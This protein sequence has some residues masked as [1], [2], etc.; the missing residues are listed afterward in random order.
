MTRVSRARLDRKRLQELT[1]HFSF[2][3]SSL[4]NGVE[5]ENF[6]NEFLT[7]EEKIMLTKRL[8]LFMMVKKNYSPTAIQS[9]LHVSYETVRT[10]QRQLQYKNASFQQ[11]IERLVRRQATK[12]FF[13]KLDKIL[14][15]LS[16]ALAAKTDMRARAKLATGDWR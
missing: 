11:T 9:A 7:E 15:P 13:A 10:Y 12:E 5:I 6:F 14:K 4:T 1:D 8:V 2:L 16:L 3:V